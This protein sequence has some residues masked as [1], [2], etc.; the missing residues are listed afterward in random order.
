M[1]IASLASDCVR[2]APAGGCGTMESPWTGWE[3]QLERGSSRIGPRTFVLAAGFYGVSR[4]VRLATGT[5]LAPEAGPEGRPWFFP[6]TT[7][8]AKLEALFLVD[9]VHEVSLA[10]LGLNGREGRAAHGLLIRCG[11]TLH[12]EGCR[13]EDFGDG[14]GAA[15]LVDGESENR[16]V[17][18]VVIRRCQLLNGAVGLRL[19]RDTTDLLVTANRF[20]EMSGPCVL[21][22]P[23]DHWS[24][25]GLIFVKNHLSSHD[26]KRRDGFV[27]VMPGAEELRIA[28]NTFE[29]PES[30]EETASWSAVE[31][32]GGGPLSAN[33]LEVMLN[34]IAGSPGPGVLARQCGP[35]FL[36]AGNRL[37]GCGSADQGSIQLNACHGILV[38]DNSI[39]EPA[40][41]GIR[42]SDGRSV[43]LNGNEIA[44]HVDPSQ[45]RRGSIGIRIDGAGTRR[46]RVTDNTVGGM[47]IAGIR[48]DDGVGLRVTGN[49][50]QD[51]G[52]GIRVARGRNLLLVGND[53]RDNGGG[54]MCV[55]SA[56]RR[57]LVALNYAIL[58]GPVDLQ[59]LG[60]RIRCHS[61]K[62]DR[63]G[64]L[65]A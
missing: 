57:G 14:D 2:L 31:I 7:S 53:C 1:S 6:A 47:K 34:T 16:F 61:N 10:G 36:V 4:P 25:Y 46:P 21:I 52:E 60:D 33:R 42:S 9:G 49:E 38:E 5:T 23:K 39:E 28:E 41:P 43:R 15:I 30:P 20:T 32:R 44:G 58:N 19:G 56:V 62:V 64:R 8:G 55:E 3:S 65:P 12:V 45:P 50:V 26:A 37:T 22:N 18:G 51:C 59:V 27:R 35:G 63:E 29:G 24:R 13:F 40:G 17:R 54:G 11:T 48:V